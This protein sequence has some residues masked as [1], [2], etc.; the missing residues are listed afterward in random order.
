MSSRTQIFG[1]IGGA[2]EHALRRIF[3]RGPCRSSRRPTDCRRRRRRRSGRYRAGISAKLLNTVAN[4]GFV[5]LGTGV[6]D[7]G[8]GTVKFDA[9]NWRAMTFLSERGNARLSQ[10]TMKGACLGD[11]GGE[12]GPFSGIGSWE[13]SQGR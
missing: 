10:V 9:I 5:A 1:G 8:K 11:T 4:P 3:R 12:K 6:H 2:V 13:N 7:G